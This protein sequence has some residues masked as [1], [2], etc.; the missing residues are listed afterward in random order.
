M[1][2]RFNLKVSTKFSS[3]FVQ[4][5]FKTPKFKGKFKK[6]NF[7]SDIFSIFPWDAGKNDD[8]DFIYVEKN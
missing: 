5:S 7:V 6:K 3:K 4:I 8:I 2:L 1:K